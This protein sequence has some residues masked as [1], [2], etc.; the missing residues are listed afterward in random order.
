MNHG[1][2]LGQNPSFTLKIGNFKDL[3]NRQGVSFVTE[4]LDLV[5]FASNFIVHIF[6][7]F[8]SLRTQ[9][10]LEFE[11]FYVSMIVCRSADLLGMPGEEVI[12]TNT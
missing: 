3:L 6:E 7:D 12:S 11:L 4:R 9:N 8:F 5:L 10:Q 1:L 2:D